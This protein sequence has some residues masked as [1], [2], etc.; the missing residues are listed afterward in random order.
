MS[1][2]P[3]SPEQLVKPRHFELRMSLIFA[4]AVRVARHASAL[5]PAVAAGQGLSCRADRR[6]PGRA[7]VPARGDHAVAH[8]ACRPGE[9]P[10]QCLCRAGAR[11]RC[12]SRRGYF[13]PPTYADG[14]GGVAGADDGLDA[15]FADRQFAG[16]CRACAASARTTR[17]CAYGARSPISAP[18]SPAASSCAATGPKAVPV[19]IFADRLPPAACCRGCWRRASAARGAPRRC[20][21]PTSST[22]RRSCS[23]PISSYFAT[24]VGVITASHAFLY[25]FVSIYWKS[26]G[27][28]DSVVGLLWAW[29][30]VAEVCMFL[31]FTR[32]SAACSV[33]RIM[34]HR[35][36]RLDRA[37]DRLSADLAARPGR[38]RL[39]RRP[40]A[41]SVC[42]R[43]DAA[44]ACRR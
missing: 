6:H 11:R 28:S 32:L 3:L 2:P 23:T 22:R 33:G 37:L 16:A 5:F 36:H 13:L 43:P 7:D 8:R 18:T 15:A 39:L 12:S 27:I 29:G 17:A 9:G 25:G 10:R 35:R 14:A 38:R 34:L 42:R 44:S 21:P 4:H 24:G 30:V 19:I 26:I 41:A 20:R 40:G 31:L 1:L